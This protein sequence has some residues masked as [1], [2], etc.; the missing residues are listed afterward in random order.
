VKEAAMKTNTKQLGMTIDLT[1]CT[2]CKTCIVA[3]SN[4]HELVDP[5][6]A[7]PNQMP[8]YL[9]VENRR[10]GA[11]PDIAVDTWV[12]PCQH[13]SEPECVAYCPEG[14]ISKDPHTGIVHIDPEIC[15]GCNAIPGAFGAEKSKTAPCMV[16][17]PA[18]I[19][20]QGYISLAAKGKYRE[21]LEL[22]KEA[23]PLPAITGRVCYHPC[24]SACKRGEIDA[25]LAINAIKRFV[26]D[27]DLNADEPYVPEIKEQKE[28]QV[29][30]VGSGPAGLTCA[31]YLAR[32]GYQVTLFEKES[33][34]GGMLTQG[35][36]SYR[37]PRDVVEAEVGLIRDMGVTV[38]TGVEIGKDVTVA[39]LREQGFKAFFLAVGTQVCLELGVEG[40]DLEGVHAGLDYLRQV[41]LGNPVALGNRVAVIGG[42]NVA[43]DVV[44][45]ARR[46]GAEDAFILYRRSMEE[47]PARPEELDDCQAEGIPIDVLTQPLRFV[48]ENGRVK[49]IECIKMR[50]TDELDDSGRPVPEPVPG[51]E[52]TIEVDAV[53][54]ALGQETDWS[55]LTPECA[56]TLTDWGTMDVDPLTFQSD[57]PDIFAGG[58]AIRGPDTVIGAI[59]DGKQAAIS[60]DRFI[61]GTDLHQGRDKAWVAVED[62]QK[63]KYEPAGRADTPSLDAQAR[64]TTFDEVQQGLAEETAVQEAQRCL[65]CGTVCIQAC[66]YT[67]IQFNG[68]EGKAHKCDLCAYRVQRG[69]LPVCAEVCLTDAIVFG[70]VAL[71]KQHA[72]EQAFSVVG[73]LSEESILYV[74]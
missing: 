40:E 22:I 2:G 34:L 62:V 28:D 30:I 9:R 36:P 26:A 8:Y 58:D 43:I 72:S 38:K 32:E 66:P 55:C 61:S 35:I 69:E 1:R 74:K 56:C 33:V 17:C 65:D 29:A 54:T 15:N 46:L 10:I 18:H 21:A 20:V 11:Y 67:V 71:L 59:A 23:N 37:L 53:I 73:D 31:Y 7:M 68:E 14:A 5:A 4:Y 27:L 47:M 6:E 41:N 57:D 42:G 24:E 25:A 44:R 39:Q 49:A 52:F 50:L 3:C 64:V 70:E 63:D 48:G 16:E 51:S 60:I 45:S 12:V 13:C 19:N